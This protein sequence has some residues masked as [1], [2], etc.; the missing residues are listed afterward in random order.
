MDELST[1]E[2]EEERDEESEEG[3]DTKLIRCADIISLVSDDS[4]DGVLDED[5]FLGL[6]ELLLEG[7]KAVAE[8]KKLWEETGE[9]F[10]IDHL[11]EE[12][13]VEDWLRQNVLEEVH[14]S[15]LDVST[16]YGNLC[17]ERKKNQTTFL[18]DITQQPSTLV[19]ISLP[20]ESPSLNLPV[21]VKPAIISK[22]PTLSKENNP[23]HSVLQ[24]S[25]KQRSMSEGFSNRS[26]S[27]KRVLV[28]SVRRLSCVPES[29]SMTAS[30]STNGHGESTRP[31]LQAKSRSWSVG[32][33]G[34]L[35]SQRTVIYSPINPKIPTQFREIFKADWFD[36][37]MT[38]VFEPP[39]DVNSS[40]ESDDDVF[41]ANKRKFGG[42]LYEI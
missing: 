42:K 15:N 31:K 7:H 23:D 16:I 3:K 9:S 30:N 20:R 22:T 6:Q 32:N 10:I 21:D 36:P 37:N 38:L 25:W 5:D 19:E 40:S 28:K 8:R 41:L 12:V 17:K 26:H 35:P 13:R 39:S 29:P 11:A 34:K 4:L 18:E 27:R 24:Q 33:L 14:D 1:D 2:E